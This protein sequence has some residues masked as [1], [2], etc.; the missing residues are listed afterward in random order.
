M[1]RIQSNFGLITG[2]D[3][4]GTVDKLM[5]ISARPREMLASRTQKIEQKQVAVTEL[6]ALLMSVRY[7]TQNLG[8]AATFDRQTITSSN[9]AA[10]GVSLTGS[11]VGGTYQFTPLRTASH[12]QYLSAGFKSDA[13][14]LG[15]GKMTFRF[16]RHLQTNLDLAQIGGGAGLARGAI[17]I[18]DRSGASAEIDLSAAQTLDDV[19]DAIN[20][21]AAIN[22]TA[23]TD[24]D[25]IRLIDNTG[26]AVSRLKVQEVGTGRTAA[27][28]GLAGVDADAPSADG[29]D[30]VRL[31]AQTDLAA[32]NDG[33]GIRTIAG[34]SEI[35]VTLRDGT[36]GVI[37][38]A[39]VADGAAAS[40][41]VKETTL[42]QVLQRINE[43][44]P[45]KLK[46]EIGPDGD[47]LVLT[48]LTSG[49]GQFR[50]ESMFGAETLQDLGLDQA[51]ADGVITG[52]RLLGGLRTV[53]LANMQGGK[54]VG[55][56]G[57]IQITDRS[58]QTAT[59][60]LAGA[61]T[62][63]DVIR[64]IND[65]NIGVSAR[66]NDAK[67]GILLTDTTG[68]TAHNLTVASAEGETTAEDLGIAVD[69]A[70]D[71]FNS[72]DLHLRVVSFNTRLSDLNGGAGV[73][74]GRFVITDSKG[75]QT[76]ISLTDPKIQTV[77]DVVLTIN[78]LSSS[79]IA[80]INETGDG[81]RL[82]D[83]A[84]G[85]GQLKVADQSGTSAADLRLTRPAATVDVSGS[86]RQVIDGSSTFTVELTQNDTLATLRNK[87]NNLQGG[88]TA[89][90]LFDGSSKPY[91]LSLVSNRSGRSGS[92]VVDT[93]QLGFELAETV[94]G[95]DALMLLGQ[96]SAAATSLMV[97]SSS[98]TFTSVLPG[99]KLE[100]KQATSTP[101]SVEVAVTD[102][103][104][105]ASVKTMV[106]NYN[107][108]RK[109]LTELTAY[110]AATNKSAILAS[111]ATA[112]RLDS[113]LGY[114]LSSRFAGVGSVQSLGELGISL[115]D[116]GTLALDETR[117][118]EKCKADLEGVKAFFTTKEAGFSARFDR[119]AEQLVGQDVSL[120][121]QRFKSLQAQVDHNLAKIE[122]MDE[123]L[124]KERDRLLLKFYHMELAIGKIQ[125]SLAAIDSLQAW[126]GSAKS[127][128]SSQE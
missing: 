21:N 109:R 31:T 99:A 87:I 119:L 108:L 26:Q 54:G 51:S 60:A 17:R 82:V 83:T 117:L 114:L 91:H 103:D 80:E 49:E 23:T 61:E 22:V 89:S 77:G 128:A 62:V 35:Q 118:R 25:R 86:T 107:K 1:G 73:G 47:R 53:L 100:V 37:D 3:I 74:R 4:A 69:Q 85:S 112:L 32:L 90:L 78:R 34:L 33:H 125:S 18:T 126:T 79:V 28:L 92:L 15:T 48:D 101:V 20:S 102:T 57:D 42:S 2:M 63:D 113:D 29:E 124:A 116:D 84:G 75:H 120:M 122:Q 50:L 39:P 13:D 64:R 66:V 11:A 14:P 24:G 30:L 123:R 96:P 93:S 110:D 81:I 71:S 46:A 44:L 59:V 38:F 7:V 12:Q 16:G 55:T 70:V 97:A 111:D 72:G 27:S 88:M 10:L 65:A 121:A 104:V 36:T 127:G 58:G 8:K 115:K 94:E 52:R 9:E 45:D 6:S 56:P 19:L 105:I 106:D 95:R 67:N 98:N 76:F 68:S 5:Q 41:A 43:A 40:T